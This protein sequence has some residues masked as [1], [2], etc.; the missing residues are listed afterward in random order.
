MFL[1]FKRGHNNRYNNY[2]QLFI[3]IIFWGFYDTAIWNKSSGLISDK[4]SILIKII[5]IILLLF[6]NL[7]YE[8]VTVSSRR[9]KVYS[10]GYPTPPPYPEPGSANF[11]LGDYGDE[12]QC[13]NPEV[14]PVISDF[15]YVAQVLKSFIIYF[16]KLAHL[17]FEH[18]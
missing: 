1:S 12:T 2:K 18:F 16:N 5:K 15:D 6:Q 11:P 9:V 17:L 8:K 13:G 3:D 7:F 10:Q 14:M 4:I